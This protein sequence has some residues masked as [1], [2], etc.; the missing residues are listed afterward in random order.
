MKHGILTYALL[1]GLG[2]VSE[3]PLVGQTVHPAGEVHVAEVREWFNYAQDKVP[4]LTKLYYGQEQFVGFSGHDIGPD[5]KKDGGH[6]DQSTN[7]RR[8]GPFPVRRAKTPT[9]I[10]GTTMPQ[11]SNN[12]H[13]V[14]E[15]RWAR[16]CISFHSECNPRR[17]PPWPT[18]LLTMRSGRPGPPTRQTPRA[19]RRRVL[20]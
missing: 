5:G 17:L 7:E 8:R 10:A 6:N 13:L 19:L 18:G 2:V 4:L 15:I 1:A 9:M 11:E 20:Q 3:G 14:S 16:N 12:G